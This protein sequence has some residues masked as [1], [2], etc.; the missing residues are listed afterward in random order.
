MMVYGVAALN[1]QG[2]PASEVKNGTQFQMT[3]YNTEDEENNYTIWPH[4]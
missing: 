4:M 3:R 2:K 1:L